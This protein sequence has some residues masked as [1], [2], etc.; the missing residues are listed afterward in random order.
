[1]SPGLWFRYIFQPT[2]RSNSKSTEMA[3]KMFAKIKGVNTGMKRVYYEETAE[4]T[5]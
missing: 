2:P 3:G 1:M 5:R 4:S